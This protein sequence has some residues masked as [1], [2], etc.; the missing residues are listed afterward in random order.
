MR[1]RS[2]SWVVMVGAGAGAVV[3]CE[4]ASDVVP[5]HAP[6]R[7]LSTLAPRLDVDA[8]EPARK[9]S[10]AEETLSAAPHVA[11]VTVQRSASSGDARVWQSRYDFVPSLLLRDG[12]LVTARGALVT[13]LEL[14]DVL[15][16]GARVR[17]GELVPMLDGNAMTFH[18]ARYENN[19]L[20][21]GLFVALAVAG[22]AFLACTIAGQVDY[23]RS[24][25]CTSNGPLDVQTAEFGFGL[26]YAGTGSMLIGGAL[27]AIYN[28]THKD[29]RIERE[30]FFDAEGRDNGAS[31]D[32]A[33][34]EA[35]GQLD[36]HKARAARAMVKDACATLAC[37]PDVC[38]A[39]LGSI[40]VPTLKLVLREE[41]EPH[42]LHATRVAI[43]GE[44]LDAAL[45]DAPFEIDP[46]RHD[47]RIDVPGHGQVLHKV[48]VQGDD[49]DK[50]EYVRIP[51]PPPPSA[52]AMPEGATVHVPAATF[53]MGSGPDEGEANERPRH[54]VRVA[55]FEIDAREVTVGAYEACV[56]AGKCRAP[57]STAAAPGLTPEQIERFS[58]RCNAVA[59][60]PRLPMN[61]VDWS[62]AD[63]Y[64]HAQGKRLPTEEEW[65][66]AA[67]GTD[68]RRYPS[69]NDAPGHVC[70]N[71]ACA[72]GSFADDVS[73][74]GVYDMAGSVNEWTASGFSGDYARPRSNDRRVVRGGS[75]L[76]AAQRQGAPPTERD[77]FL[78][79]RCAR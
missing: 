65:E 61:C 44:P 9:T 33:F 21:V 6:V 35:R 51:S 19:D 39:T 16:G 17:D 53:A 55:A 23:C 40:H 11:D 78:G 1:I 49:H 2:W 62:E 15:R 28:A 27:G 4:P 66:L 76:R 46:G 50:E 13:R 22:A 45:L 52:P 57:Q 60:D 73:A 69:G 10:V 48:A 75:S 26:A 77:P 41:G 29:V 5:V 20:E 67:R 7:S 42:P 79:F 25:D 59:Q 58:A 12:T 64:C 34:A 14:D 8:V 43:D 72:V 30:T 38:R 3:G 18:R 70:F 71:Q 24:H 68:G 37:S 31:C 36:M 54:V 63:A 32:H 47:L 56:G 74:M